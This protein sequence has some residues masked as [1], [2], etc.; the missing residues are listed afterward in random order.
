[1]ADRIKITPAELQA[2]ATEMKTLE[3]EFSDL[4]SGVSSE[5]G[6]I[7]KN[8][9][10]NL[11]HNFEGKINSAQKSFS[12]ITQELLNGAKMADRAASSYADADS[13]LVKL[14]EENTILKTATQLRKDI[15]QMV[16]KP[17]E[18]DIGDYSLKVSHSEY[19]KLCQLWYK[20]LESKD[21]RAAFIKL[22]NKHLQEND[23][24][25]SV[26]YSQLTSINSWTGFDTL[27]I[28]D[29]DTAIVIFAGTDISRVGDVVTDIKLASGQLS[30][31]EVQAISLV[32]GLTEHY[33][34]IVVTGH[35]LGGYLATAATLKVN[36]VSECVAFDSPGRYD[37]HLQEIFNKKRVEKIT[38]YEANGSPISDGLKWYSAGINQNFNT[39]NLD[40]ESKDNFL[41]HGIKQIHEAMEKDDRFA[42]MGDTWK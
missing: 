13:I 33:G 25:R 5:L 27:V 30:L 16:E 32:E 28:G 39:V 40:V 41:N 3:V 17:A 11:S 19:A 7:N 20:A 36:G 14:S 23:P 26:A 35:S 9:S 42:H 21:P 8:W 22:I 31:Q 6:K 37:A 4:F 29:G 24:L 2:Q 15:P 38:T 34:K 12:H 1:M 10:P 18:V